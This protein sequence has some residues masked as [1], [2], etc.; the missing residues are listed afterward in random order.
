MNSRLPLTNCFYPLLTRRDEPH[1]P[2]SLNIYHAT[3]RAILQS[4]RWEQLRRNLKK[5]RG[6]APLPHPH[7]LAQA[8]KDIAIDLRPWRTG[9]IELPALSIDAEWRSEIKWDRIKP[10]LPPLQDKVVGDIG[11]SNGYFLFRLAELNPE[12]VVGLDP[13]DRCFLQFALTNLFLQ[14]DRIAFLPA[15]LDTLS[16][17]QCYFDCLLCMGV[18]Y[19]QRDPFTAVRT[20]YNAIKPGGTL[21]LESLSIPHAD[22]VLLIPR[23]RYAKMRNAWSIPSPKA[24]EN[25]LLKA[26][27]T[28]TSIHCFGAITTEE[29]RRTEYAH[30]ESLADFLD[31]ADCSKTVE[32]Y[33]APHSTVVLGK[34][35]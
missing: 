24:M 10:L 30:F 12:L 26:G 8:V 2:L 3:L 32:G 15:G 18:I 21:L 34:K 9:P 25:L 29:Q 14:S 31:P 27:F 22:E 19:H 17:F 11:C 6:T 1:H 7:K 33:P 16:H 20:L 4:K 35:P 23:D 13:V 5:C 28:E